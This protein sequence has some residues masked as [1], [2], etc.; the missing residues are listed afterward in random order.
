M[1]AEKKKLIDAPALAEQD[2]DAIESGELQ[3]TDTPA[4]GDLRYPDHES[5]EHPEEDDDNPQQE[6]DEAL[7]NDREEAALKRDS[8][9]ESGL[10]DEV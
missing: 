8:G 2:W 4:N 7:P 10:F 3:P 9:K 5:G 1:N 6:S